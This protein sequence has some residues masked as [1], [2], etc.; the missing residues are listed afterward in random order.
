[1]EWNLTP[2]E[3]LISFDFDKEPVFLN[4]K[5]YL[6]LLFHFQ[7][8]IQMKHKFLLF[9]LLLLS[10]PFGL[11]AQKVVELKVSGPINGVTAEYIKEAI[12]QAEL[13][14]ADCILLEL[15]TPGGL[16]DA[17]RSIVGDI[18]EASV[19]VVVFVAPSGAHAGSAGVFITISGNIAAMAPG[20]NIGAAHPVQLFGSPDSVMNLKVMNDAVA[21]IKTIAENRNKNWEWAVEAVEHSK[22]I[23]EKEA[24]SLNVIDLIALNKKDLLSKIDGRVVQMSNGKQITLKTKDAVIEKLDMGSVDK[25]LYLINDPNVMY[26]LFLIGIFGVVME[27]FSPGAI[28]P[29]VIGVISLILAFYSMSMLPV[30]YA[31]VALIIFGVILFILEIKIISHG[32]LGLGA[33]SSLLIGSL[34]LIRKNSS[35]DV[36]GIS[37]YV[38]FTSVILITLL[39]AIVIYL[40]LKAQKNKSVT[41]SEGMTE[42]KGVVL[43]T[44]NP[45]GLIR[46]HG[47]IWTA[48]SLT[49]FIEPGTE[50]KVKKF[51]GLKAFVEPII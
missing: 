39:L 19:P 43:E 27:F 1:M 50:V 24:L 7:Y 3:K 17:T 26:V 23:S 13:K 35:L 29:G 36:I 16:L 25:M 8:Y 41:G 34:M 22:S 49:G 46:L 45:I 33:V 4:K 28:I 14:Q 15:N 6:S 40:G 2:E 42:E 48:E 31:G 20:T 30:N 5:E 9:I 11:F 10:I 38:I 18:M 37:N 12:A 44:L 47:E 21:F 51:I 32:M